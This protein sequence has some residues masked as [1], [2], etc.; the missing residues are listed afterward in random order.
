MK[1]FVII[2]LVVE[3]G[4]NA[5]AQSHL[6]YQYDAAGNRVARI[7]FDA[8]QPQCNSHILRNSAEILVNPTVTTDLVTITTILDVEQTPMCYTLSN[9]QGNV[10]ASGDIAGQ[11]IKLSLARFASGIY[12]ITVRTSQFSQS[13]KIIKR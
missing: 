9:L 1:Y 11:Q 12:L 8:N 6:L 2:L 7:K 10:L 4:F 5:I 3:L 13:F